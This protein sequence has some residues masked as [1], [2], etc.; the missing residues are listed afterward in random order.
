MRRI[1]IVL[2]LFVV[3]CSLSGAFL[4][5]LFPR[6]WERFGFRVFA[7]GLVV[8]LLGFSAWLSGEWLSLPALKRPGMI[9][10]GAM[11]VTSALLTV[12]LP[13]WGTL[14]WLA[15]RKRRGE[16]ASSGPTRRQFLSGAAA[17]LPTFSALAG[18]VGAAS[19]LRDPVL[20]RVDI[21]VPH[22][23]AGL[24]GLKILHVTD[25][26]LGTFIDVDQVEAAVALARP[27]APDLVALTGDLA[28]DYTKL[29]GA[30]RALASLETPLGLFA[31][32][33]NHEL[34]RGRAEAERILRE[35]GVHYLCGE[36][37]L[38]SYRGEKLFIAGADDP[39]RM[40][41]DHRPF[42]EKTV[43]K[44]FADCPPSVRARILL[45]HRPEGFE[46]GARYGALLTLAGHTHGAQAAFF[47]RSW[48]EW[49]LPESYLLG[50][51]RNQES[52]LYTSAGLGHWFPFRFNCPCEAALITLKRD[53]AV[54][55]DPA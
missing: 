17:V 45:S 27:E 13:A 32:I 14:G 28:D 31:C 21:R 18:P 8:A 54:L 24:D 36:G 29:P 39:G 12:T 19:S 43:K 4:R 15:G 23:P 48:L 50:V 35:A 26:H 3:F 49:L 33:G 55:Q 41:Q 9:A 22:L 7:G 38:L 20:R 42:L 16:E 47:G 37:L 10:F 25:I 34:Y 46:A 52:F 51:Y 44:A 30:L 5:R 1:F 40:G 2:V 6:A 53:P 11:L